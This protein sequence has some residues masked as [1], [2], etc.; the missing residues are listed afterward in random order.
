MLRPATWIR[1]DAWPISATRRPATEA[2]GLS[3][4]GL[5]KLSGQ[6]LRPPPSCQRASSTSPLSCGRPGEKNRTP[7][8]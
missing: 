2:G 5:G 7:S 4:N 8:K 3:R 1:N 6:S